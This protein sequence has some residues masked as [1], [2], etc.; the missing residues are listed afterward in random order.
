MSTSGKRP[1]HA[2]P[3]GEREGSGGAEAAALGLRQVAEQPLGVLA[4]AA[5]TSSVP[6]TV[7]ETTWVAAKVE[8]AAVH[9][10][11]VVVN[12]RVLMNIFS[13]V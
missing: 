4:A 12:S 9:V 1:K 11:C 6:G 5:S 10:K 7:Q 8:V 3:T 2:L 13:F